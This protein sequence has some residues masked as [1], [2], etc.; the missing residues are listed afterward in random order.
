MNIQQSTLSLQGWR[1]GLRLFAM[2][3]IMVAASGCCTGGTREAVAL[4]PAIRQEIYER[5]ERPFERALLIKPFRNDENDPIEVRLAPFIFFE[6]AAVTNSTK[7]SGTNQPISPIVHL[8]ESKALI[9]GHSY[10]QLSYVWESLPGNAAQRCFQGVR[11]T[12]SDDGDPV[13]WEI[14]N[15]PSGAELVFVAQSVEADAMKKLGAPLKERHFSVERSTGEAPRM[16]I[17]T[18]VEN[19]P[20]AMGPMVFVNTNGAVSA[21]TCRCMP[22]QADQLSG[23]VVYRI[24]RADVKNTAA[25]GKLSSFPSD[26]F[27]PRRLERVLRVREL[28]SD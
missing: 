4:D 7:A 23:E 26:W 25:D 1:I 2:S 9:G 17:A 14:L 16:V 12:L 3:L 20:A 24:S 28:V 21:L 10:S 15:D 6:Q 27:D 18:I 5:A 11:L 8:S 19:G 22:V 13:A